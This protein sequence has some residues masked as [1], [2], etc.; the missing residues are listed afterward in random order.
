[1]ILKVLFALRPGEEPEALACATEF[2]H[3]MNPGYLLQELGKARDSAAGYTII[4]VLDIELSADHVLSL[5]LPPSPLVPAT[6]APSN[7]E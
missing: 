5:L 7:I 1:M 2:D 3:D 4:R 6:A